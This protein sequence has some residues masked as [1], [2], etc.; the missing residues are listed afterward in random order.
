MNLRTL[1]DDQLHVAAFAAAQ[2]EREETLNVL[3]H[4][5][6]SVRSSTEKLRSVISLVENK[7]W[8]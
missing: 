3:R 8:I 2:R 6:K 4:L 1:S 7:S 5:S